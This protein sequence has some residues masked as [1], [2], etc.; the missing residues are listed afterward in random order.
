MKDTFNGYIK[1]PMRC[2]SVGSEWEISE[3]SLLA[4]WHAD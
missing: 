4:L 2:G 1:R 3:A